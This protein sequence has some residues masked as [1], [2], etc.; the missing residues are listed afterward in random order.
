MHSVTCWVLEAIQELWQQSGRQAVPVSILVDGS[1]MN[2][3]AVIPQD[4]L[5]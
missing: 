4:S 5:T 1:D 2:A 3:E